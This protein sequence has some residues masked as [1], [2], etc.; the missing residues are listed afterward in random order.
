MGREK[1]PEEKD[2]LLGY[3]K[4][5]K[6]GKDDSMAEGRR[7]RTHAWIFC[8]SEVP[9]EVVI[10]SCLLGEKAGI[11]EIGSCSVSKVSRLYPSVNFRR[12]SSGSIPSYCTSGSTQPEWE[13]GGQPNSGPLFEMS[14]DVLTV[15]STMRIP[16][17]YRGEYSQWVERFMNY[18]EEQT[19]GEAMINSIKNGDQP[20][21][22]VTQVSIAGTTLTEQPPLKDKSMWSDQ[23]KRVQKIDRL[24]RSLL[25]QGL[26]N[27]IYSLIDS[28]TLLI[29]H[30]CCYKCGDSLNN[31]FCHQ[32]TYKFCGNGA[33]DVYNCPSE[34]EDS[35]RMGN[36]HLDTIL[37]TES[38]EFI[39]A[40]V[41]NLIPNP[42]ESEDLSN[43]CPNCSLVRDFTIVRNV[44]PLT[45]ITTTA[46]VPL[47]KLV[48]LESNTSKPVYLD[49]GC[50]KHM[51]GDRSQLTNFV[52]KFL[53]TVKFGNDHFAKIMG[54]GDYKIGN[55]TILRVYFAEGLGNNL[56]S[57]G[58]FCDSDLEVAF[59]QHTCFIQVVATTCYTQNQ[60]IVRVHHGKTPYELLHNKLPDLSFLHVFGALWYPTNDSENLGK[61]QPKADIGIFIVYT[62]TKKSFRIYNRRTRRIVETIHFDFD[63]LTIMAS[64]QSTS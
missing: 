52:N 44:Y 49:S 24:A 16:L 51:T 3:L 12:L 43:S 31:F 37:E 28:V 25:I 59:R 60:S 5:K 48:P 10:S 46:I 41:E 55:V 22:R 33:H 39:K 29:D 4:I 17:L 32:C 2:F 50:S 27:D 54:Y 53:G 15:G 9:R 21:P 57:V 40:S 13:E 47:R 45:R 30:H 8:L 11:A 23:E 58:Q 26:P 64:E 20:L 42:S 62:P 6:G 34:P 19:D 35:L 38:D 1:G 18:I 63:E 56:F 14:R 36:E 7:E 61:L